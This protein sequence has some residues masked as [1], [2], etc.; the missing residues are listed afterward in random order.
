MAAY[1]RSARNDRIKKAVR[2]RDRRGRQ[3]QGRIIV[4]GCREVHRALCAGVR[5][6]EVFV[7]DEHVH[8]TSIQT[9][10]AMLAPH[11][12]EAA[13]VTDNVFRKIAFGDRTDGI[14][15]VAA[16]P[17][18]SLEKL[19]LPRNSLICVLEGVEKPGNVGAILRTADAAGID[20]VIITEAGTD[21]YNP[22]AIRA[23]LGAIFHLPVCAARSPAAVQWLRKE[24]FAV[25]ASRIEAAT[26]YASVDYRGKSALVVGSEAEGLTD[27][28]TGKEIT[29]VALPMLG[30]VDSLN[31]SATAAVLCYEA[32][33]QRQSER[34]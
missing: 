3:R 15:L 14:V 25:F 34:P 28:W 17:R 32:V 23:S 13:V 8:D 6:L 33:R 29:A 31:V 18:L 9:I 27:I 5:P 2:L 10:T 26:H 19:R 12:I 7:S 4:D 21:L 24:Q 11:E 22:N 30:I 1:I 20:A 16:E